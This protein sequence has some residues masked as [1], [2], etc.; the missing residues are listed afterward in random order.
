MRPAAVDVVG[1][2]SISTINTGPDAG[3]NA[4]FA[5][6]FP[7]AG[8]SAF[9]TQTAVLDGASIDRPDRDSHHDG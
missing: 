8:V 4:T 6:I 3:M 9:S 5:S 2:N 7:P 1:P